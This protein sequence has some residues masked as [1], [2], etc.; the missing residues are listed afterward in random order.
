MKTLTWKPIFRNLEETYVELKHLHCRLFYLAFGELPDDVAGDGA[1]KAGLAKSERRD[2]FTERGLYVSLD[3]AFHHLNW[4]WNVRRTP[5]DRVWHFTEKEFNR[6]SKFPKTR[7]FAALWPSEK[8]NRRGPG[9]LGDRKVSL[10][11]VRVSIQMAWRKLGILCARIAKGIGED[12]SWH[13]CPDGEGDAVA[14]PLTEREFALRM[15]RIYAKLNYAWNSRHD[16]S[17]VV[18]PHA[19]LRRRCFSPMFMGNQP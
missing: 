6:W 11:P 10:T 5:E 1:C 14:Q 3:H 18:G 16:K 19:I 12:S 2:P 8:S 15:H 9:K 17:F 13:P 7:E 4:A